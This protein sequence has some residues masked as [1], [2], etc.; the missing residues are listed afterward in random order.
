MTDVRDQAK[1]VRDED[2]F[3]VAAVH[4]WLRERVD[5]LGDALP[6]VQQ[7][8]GGASNLTY[9]LRYA[10]RDLILRRPPA[11]TKAASAHDMARE[12]RVQARLKPVFPYVPEMV[13]FCDDPAV[14]GSEF[15]VMERLEGIILRANLPRGLELS[16][17]QVRELCLAVVDR[18]IDLHAIDPDEAGLADLGRGAGYVERQVRGWSERY[19]AAKTWNVPSFEKVMAWL[20]ANR[21]D[22]VATRIIHNDFRFDNVVLD[23]DDPT[24]IVGILDWE[25]ATLGDPLM[26]LGASLAYWVEAGDDRWFAMFRRQPTHAPGMLTRAEVVARYRERTDLP[27]ADWRFYEVYGLFRLAVIVQQIYAR[28][29][30]KQTRNPAFKRFWLAVH[31][32]DRRCR[33]I[34][35]KG[36]V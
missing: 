22:D 9:L 31:I 8:S 16:E 15:Y 10:D 26:D 18:L 23:P 32:L 19:R 30:A 1:A 27:I 13:A 20:E 4:R 34:I 29:H 36:H 25:M 21:P 12:H 28:Y 5:G 7:F 35:R 33:R 14:I 11:G 24:R 6:Q 3:D 2:A 17:A